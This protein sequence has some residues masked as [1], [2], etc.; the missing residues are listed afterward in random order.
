M[1]FVAFLEGTGTD[2][3]GRRIAALFE[4]SDLRLELK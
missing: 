3:K 4:Y 2:D 1:N